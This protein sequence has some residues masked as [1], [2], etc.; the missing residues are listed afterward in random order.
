MLGGWPFSCFEHVLAHR[1]R[2]ARGSSPGLCP[3]GSPAAPALGTCAPAVLPK[4]LSSRART[5]MQSS[6]LWSA[7]VFLKHCVFFSHRDRACQS[8]KAGVCRYACPF[9][10][11][12][13]FPC[14]IYRPFSVSL[15][16][17]GLLGR[18]CWKPAPLLPAFISV[19]SSTVPLKLTQ[20]TD[21]VTDL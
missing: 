21:H 7:L 19:F 12:S 3:P 10:P 4:S 15:R 5:V 9:C 16:Q 13:F 2:W 14:Q 1:R 11:F 6:F 18:S 20:H 8:E 17:V